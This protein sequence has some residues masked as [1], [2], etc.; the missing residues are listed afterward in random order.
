MIVE[1]KHSDVIPYYERLRT[2]LVTDEVK[3]SFLIGTRKRNIM[4]KTESAAY[5]ALTPKGLK[6]PARWDGFSGKRKFLIFS[7][8]PTKN[9][10]YGENS[11]VRSRTTARIIPL[12][13]VV[14]NQCGNLRKND[15]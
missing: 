11:S 4:W 10:S 3:K 8:S 9:D 12:K 1:E 15:L 5:P 13:E 14:R 7:T 6:Q 2:Y